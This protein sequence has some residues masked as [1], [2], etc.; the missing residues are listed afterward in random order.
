MDTDSNY[1]AIN[2]ANLE[3]VIKP[4]MQKQCEKEWAEWL[5]D[6]D[7]AEKWTKRTPGLFK[8]DFEGHRMIA[9]CTKCFFVEGEYNTK[10]EGNVKEVGHN[11]VDKIQSRAG[12]AKRHG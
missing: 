8:L 4:G 9:L 6:P 2:E 7:P 5:A 11:H 3:A 1:F 10:R 12:V